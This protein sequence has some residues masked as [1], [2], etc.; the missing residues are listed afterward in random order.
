[1]K[2]EPCGSSSFLKKTTY[3]AYDASC[4]R[5]VKDNALWARVTD[6]RDGTVCSKYVSACPC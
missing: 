4:Y 1:M 2:Y 5:L 6:T 3:C